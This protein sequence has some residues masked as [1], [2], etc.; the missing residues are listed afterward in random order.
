MLGGMAKMA[1]ATTV[2]ALVLWAFTAPA[3]AGRW[4]SP[5]VSVRLGVLVVLGTAVYI[6]VA[7][8]FRIE[9]WRVLWERR[10]SNSVADMV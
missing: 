8:V 3:L 4:V 6:L 10:G 9:E 1:G 2:M 7:L 5:L